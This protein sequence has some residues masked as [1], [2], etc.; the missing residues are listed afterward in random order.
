MGLKETI[1][2]AVGSGFTALGNLRETVTYLAFQTTS[3]YAPST[4]TYT[5]TETPYALSGLFVRYGQRDIDGVQI[6]PHDQKFLFVPSALPVEPQLND[7]LL[8]ADGS[9]WEVIDR[10]KDPAS[11]L[12]SLQVRGQ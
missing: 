3:A 2:G 8:R 1:Q 6:K 10:R 9:Y 11:A 7:R 5:R 4:G 12:W